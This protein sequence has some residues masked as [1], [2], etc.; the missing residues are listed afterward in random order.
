MAKT[1]LSSKGQIVIP[2]QVRKTLD[3]RVGDEFDCTVVEGRIV[4]EPLGVGGATIEV[5]KDGFPALNAP[6]GAPEMTPDTVK[7]ILRDFP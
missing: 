5:E 3:L 4:L 6:D 2:L 7:A 1:V